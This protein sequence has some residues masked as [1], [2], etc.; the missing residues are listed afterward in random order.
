M[1][2]TLHYFV[3]EFFADAAFDAG[4]LDFLLAGALPFTDV[5]LA[6]AD[7]GL[8]D[9][10]FVPVASFF[11]V[12]FALEVFL[13]AGLAFVAKLLTFAAFGL[14]TEDV[15]FLDKLCRKCKGVSYPVCHLFKPV[16]R[17]PLSRQV[18]P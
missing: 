7:L 13:P 4:A 6:F 18:L 5:G 15:F 9:V 8:A 16:D 1:C 3:G 12:T 2:K 10:G 14:D 11:G 17:I